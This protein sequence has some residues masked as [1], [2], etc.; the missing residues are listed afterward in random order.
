MKFLPVT[1]WAALMLGNVSFSVLGADGPVSTGSVVSV[2]KENG[3][4]VIDAAQSSAGRL[5]FYGMDR[6]RIETVGG[7]PAA[8]GDLR[9]GS[10]V[11]VYYA[12]ADKRWVI[13]KVLIPE[14][15]PLPAAPA[16][17]SSKEKS[18]TDADPTTNPGQKAG[19]DNDRTTKPPGV[20]A[21]DGDR[22]TNPG[23]KAGIDK[24][25][26][27]QP[28]RNADKDGDRTTNPANKAGV[29]NDITTTPPRSAGTDGDRTTKPD[30]R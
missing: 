8:I 19:I 7:K 3:T 1:L 29:D 20:A 24:D 16:V 2:S 9:P 14:P 26:T 5:T 25:I 18:L 12:P 22:T 10:Q 27:T 23:N 4:L 6:A 17:I 11:T 30:N 13:S 15:A 28:P 21:R